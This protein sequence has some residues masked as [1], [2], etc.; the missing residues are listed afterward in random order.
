MRARALQSP[1]LSLYDTD[2]A[3]WTEETARLLRAGR[4][5]EVDLDHV[6]EEIEDMGKRDSREVES[7]LRILLVH[8]LKRKFQPHKRSRSWSSTIGNQRVELQQTFV[9]S[10]SLR[11]LPAKSL[12]HV[13]RDAVRLVALETGLSP[14]R[15]PAECPFRA[16]QMLDHDFPPS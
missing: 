3:A 12:E 1:P 8:L 6:A 11:R 13:Y 5:R 14:K 2:F 9:Q 10:P 7:R 4:F 15:F 16:E